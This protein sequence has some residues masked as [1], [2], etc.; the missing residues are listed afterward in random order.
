M[1]TASI[2]E[3]RNTGG[4]VVERARKGEDVTITSSGRPVAV[5]GPLPRPPLTLEVILSR[6]ASLPPIDPQALRDD[7]DAVLDP[8]L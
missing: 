1:A 7:L 5:L 4:E 3:L 2:R 8:G 6:R